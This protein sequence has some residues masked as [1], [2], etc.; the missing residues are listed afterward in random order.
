MRRFI[1]LVV[2][3]APLAATALLRAAGDPPAWAYAIPLPPTPGA[4]A[5]APDTSMK[6]L[7]GSTLSFTRQQIADGFGPADWFPGDHPT[8]PDIVAHGKRPDAR[9]CALCHMPNGKGRQE[10]AGVSGLPVSYFIQQMNDFRSGVRKS[11]EPR[12]ANTNVMIAI[13]KAMTPD[14]IRITAEY[15]GAMKWTPWIR[16]VETSTVAKMESRGGI[17]IPVEGGQK[18]PIGVRII[19]T[20][21]NPERTE[22]LRDPRSGFIAYVPVGSI[23]KGEALV[24]TGGN[25]KTEECGVCHGADLQGLGPVPGIAGRSPSYLVRQMYDMQA[26]ARHGEWADLMKPVV[27]KLTDEDFVNIAAYVSS[28]M[29][30]NGAATR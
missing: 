6:Q 11:A 24:K 16:V 29:P 2:L 21:E 4:P 1:A 20:P 7:P 28:L 19:E 27:A 17:W 9:A 30:S 18:E 26:G 15:F 13:A 5:A 10:N 23:R 3:A 8:M 12:K 25:R 22:I 14:E